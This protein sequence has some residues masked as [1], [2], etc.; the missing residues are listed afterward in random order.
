MNNFLHDLRY[1]ARMMRKNLGFTAIAV[2]TLALGIGANTALF[3]VINAVLLRPLPF[4][5]PGRLV[6]LTAPDPKDANHGGEIS[7]PAFLDWRQQSHSFD[8]MSVWTTNTYTYTGGDHPESVPGAEVSANLFSLL[9]VDPVLGRTFSSEEDEPRDQLPLVLSF[10][11]WQNHFG[12]D[13]SVIGR[14][15][16]LDSQKYSIVGVMPAH[17]QFP[18]QA[19]R[20]ELWTTMATDLTGPTPM[21]KQR[22]VSYLQM[23]G[24]LKPDVVASLIAGRLNLNHLRRGWI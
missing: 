13:R 5:D 1:A 24:R 7:Y 9:G 8:A 12:G 16:T 14:S 18:I 3:S 15:I 11:F 6:A 4:R 20:E 2:A 19:G 17:F 23:V 21:A 22:G 10:E